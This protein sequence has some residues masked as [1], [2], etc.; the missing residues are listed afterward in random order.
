[1]NILRWRFGQIDVVDETEYN[2]F[3]D[4]WNEGILSRY[5][6]F[7]KHAAALVPQSLGATD[8]VAKA[9]SR[10]GFVFMPLARRDLLEKFLYYCVST[11]I[12]YEGETYVHND[13]A[14][15]ETHPKRDQIL[16]RLRKT[17][18]LESLVLRLMEEG[19]DKSLY[20]PDFFQRLYCKSFDEQGYTSDTGIFLPKKSI[21]REIL[22]RAYGKVIYFDTQY[23]SEDP[24]DFVEIEHLILAD[25]V[26][27]KFD[28]WG[29]KLNLIEVLEFWREYS[30]NQGE[31]WSEWTNPDMKVLLAIYRGLVFEEWEYKLKSDWGSETHKKRYA[32]ACKLIEDKPSLRESTSFGR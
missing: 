30:D 4:I 15:K 17:K 27:A 3:R 16:A 22:D 14:Y 23:L 24:E 7:D 28:V 1:M 11:E 10:S 9:N 6:D 32:R 12:K 29:I 5:F 18:S 19:K 31:F 13:E 21:P 2:E 8:F 26:R 20:R 25:K